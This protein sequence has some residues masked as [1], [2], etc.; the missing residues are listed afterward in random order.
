[1]NNRIVMTTIEEDLAKMRGLVCKDGICVLCDDDSLLQPLSEVENSSRSNTHRHSLKESADRSALA[2][3]EATNEE[4]DP[5]IEALAAV[6]HDIWVDWSKAV[7]KE[8]S[9]ARRERWEDFW[10][11]YSELS[12]EEKE[13]DREFARRYLDTLNSTE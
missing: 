2:V 7:S 4:L 12:E 6:S 1:M 8:V 13:T 5:R 9:A 11:P 10:V 3:R